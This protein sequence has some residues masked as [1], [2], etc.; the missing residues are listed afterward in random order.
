VVVSHSRQATRPI[1]MPHRAIASILNR[2]GK[3]TGEWLDSCRHP[4]DPAA[5]ETAHRAALRHVGRPTAW[6][7]K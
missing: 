1:M 5:F 6:L 3:G 7:G 4:S 2:A